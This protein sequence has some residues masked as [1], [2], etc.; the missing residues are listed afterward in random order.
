[1][2]LELYLGESFLQVFFWGAH[3]IPSGAQGSF[4]MGLG[5]FL[6]PGVIPKQS[7][8]EAQ[9][10]AGMCPPVPPSKVKQK[11]KELCYD[12]GI[13]LKK[14]HQ[15][16]LTTWSF[17][18]NL[19]VRSHCLVVLRAP[20]EVLGTKWVGCIQDKKFNPYTIPPDPTFPPWSKMYIKEL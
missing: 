9:S 13:S 15:M 5:S 10:T 19:T 7:Q 1:M 6:V 8:E 2:F 14:D 4:L 18:T 20:Y 11:I 12:L 3:I 16:N 17:L